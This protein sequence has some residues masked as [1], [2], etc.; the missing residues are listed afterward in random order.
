MSSAISSTVAVL[1]S[2]LQ[3]LVVRITSPWYRP[4]PVDADIFGAYNVQFAATLDGDATRLY[5]AAFPEVTK[6]F[7]DSVDRPVCALSGSFDNQQQVIEAWENGFV[8]I[9]L[10][11][12]RPAHLERAIVEALLKTK[13]A[14]V[15]KL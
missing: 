10:E 3:Y 6:R 14:E 2:P 8:V 1:E 5:I 7:R 15:L 12:D 13:R 4:L 11:G 9:A